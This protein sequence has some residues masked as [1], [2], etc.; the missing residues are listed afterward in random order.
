MTTFAERLH[1]AMTESGLT[2]KALAEA[3]GASKAAISQ[4]LGG[5]N[6][7][8]RERL[9]AIAEVVGV[10]PDYLR[11]TEPPPVKLLKGLPKRITV[12]MAAELLGLSPQAVRVNM[13]S[14]QLPIGRALPGFGSRFI[15]IITPEKLR[16]EAGAS[17]FNEYF[18][19]TD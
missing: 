14:G 10:T 15:Y 2:Q 5:H 11:G 19:L 12:A 16:D 3:V 8:S 4:Y 13:R 9:E 6:A 7:P 17:R 1:A 18:G